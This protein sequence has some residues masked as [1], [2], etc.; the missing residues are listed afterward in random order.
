MIGAIGNDLGGIGRRSIDTVTTGSDSTDFGA[1]IAST[2]TPSP[3][4]APPPTD[5]R[6]LDADTK[7]RN[8]LAAFRKEA[9]MTPAERA[10]RDVL[11]SMDLTEEAIEAMTPE[12]RKATEDKIA[13]EVA[14]RM[15]AAGAV[16]WRTAP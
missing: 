5:R 11:E 4:K 10:R 6:A 9:S 12:Q 15:R 3:A 14:R 8:A 2:G 16:G 13:A 7:L 1:L